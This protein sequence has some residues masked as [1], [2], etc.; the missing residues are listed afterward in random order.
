VNSK[1]KKKKNLIDGF[2][3]SDQ[4]VGG[5]GHMAACPGCEQ[6]SSYSSFPALVLLPLEPKAE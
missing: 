6:S 5:E 3:Q 1:K 2:R 4:W